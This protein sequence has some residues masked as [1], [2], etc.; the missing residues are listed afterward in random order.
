MADKEQKLGPNV[1]YVG[2][3][4]EDKQAV[5]MMGIRFKPGESVNLEERLGKQ[6]SAAVLQKLAGNQYFKVD[7]G[8][9][10]QK[11]KEERE[12]ADEKA[13]ADAQKEA[14]EAQAEQ[15][16]APEEST[17]ERPRSP[18]R[19]G[20]SSESSGGKTPGSPTPD[21]GDDKTPP[22]RKP[23]GSPTFGDDDDKPPPAR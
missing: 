13:S 14:E 12:K 8:P 17:L 4:E 15:Y 18:P 2:G 10:H 20:T 21:E 5:T 16:K 7:G 22:A 9:D 6:Q 1:T 3:G 19:R 23:P 11:T